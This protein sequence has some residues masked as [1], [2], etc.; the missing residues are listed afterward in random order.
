METS[1]P[2][3]GSSWEMIVWQTHTMVLTG[4]VQ[5]KGRRCNV[6]IRLCA[7]SAFPGSR[8]GDVFVVADLLLKCTCWGLKVRSEMKVGLMFGLS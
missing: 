4:P 8:L 1:G 5:A 6:L 2:D 7:T 3:Q